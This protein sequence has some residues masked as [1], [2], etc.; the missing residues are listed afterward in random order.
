MSLMAKSPALRISSP[1]FVRLCGTGTGS[2]AFQA[3]IRWA[4]MHRAS[5]G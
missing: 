1:F 4:A 3:K 2:S 5:E